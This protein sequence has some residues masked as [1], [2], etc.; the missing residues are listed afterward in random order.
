MSWGGR[1]RGRGSS[2]AVSTGGNTW[3]R[4]QPTSMTTNLG[5]AS[6]NTCSWVRPKGNDV[7]KKKANNDEVE[8][9][10]AKEI[11]A[12]SGGDALSASPEKKE[13]KPILKGGPKPSGGSKVWKRK[14][15]DNNGDND[16]S[17][18]HVRPRKQ[19]PPPRS[20]PKKGNRNVSRGNGA[21]APAAKRIRLDKGGSN[22]ATSKS[23][24]DKTSDNDTDMPE[25]G[26]AKRDGNAATLTA[27]A[28]REIGAAERG[29][30]RGRGRGNTKSAGNIGL[31]RVRAE[32][33]STTKICPTFARGINC[34]DEYCRKRHDVPSECARPLCSFFQRHGQ[35][36][37]GDDCPFAHVKVDPRAA[38][39]SSFQLLGYCE[40]PNCAFKHVLK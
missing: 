23:D 14:S 29:R 20:I 12:D 24:E 5:G 33:Q 17:K 30:G 6:S 2:N 35:C 10:L 38:V 9:V 19:N 34:D 27:F 32:L 39:C 28:Y 21:K 22:D 16:K 7:D 15:D 3:K 13:Q 25:A 11:V 1:G 36:R 31:V 4:G 18:A 40:D 37:K 8:E 26:Q